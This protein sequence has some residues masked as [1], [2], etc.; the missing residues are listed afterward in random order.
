VN[1]MELTPTELSSLIQVQAWT[2]LSFLG[3][4]LTARSLLGH[5][6]AGPSL[7]IEVIDFNRKPRVFTKRFQPTGYNFTYASDKLGKVRIPFVVAKVSVKWDE[8]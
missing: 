4:A 2:C 6:L 5:A 1:R 7:L 8:K 3:S